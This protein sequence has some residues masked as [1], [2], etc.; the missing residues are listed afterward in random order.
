MGIPLG[1]SSAAL[2]AAGEPI[3]LLGSSG[4]ASMDAL[5]LQKRPRPNRATPGSMTTS[6]Q[7]FTCFGLSL[8]RCL[9]SSRASTEALVVP[10]ARRKLPTTTHSN[11]GTSE[12]SNKGT[13][14]RANS[15]EREDSWSVELPAEM[16][17]GQF[18]QLATE[19]EA[20]SKQ[21]DRANHSHVSLSDWS[22]RA[23][24]RTT[25]AGQARGWA[26]IGARRSRRT[27]KS[28][29]LFC[30]LLCLLC[31]FDASYQGQS[32]KGHRV[33]L[34]A[35]R[36]RK[37]EKG[38]RRKEKGEET[39]WL[40]RAAAA[41]WQQPTNESKC[42]REQASNSFPFLARSGCLPSNEAEGN[43]LHL[44]PT[45]GQRLIFVSRSR[46][47][48]SSRPGNQLERAPAKTRRSK[49]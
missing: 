7:L 29:D 43:I 13:S 49:K 20:G 36:P 6:G 10:F 3:T 45:A 33:R 28:L 2:A 37:Q 23:S 8:A 14:E 18:P 11:A 48:Q 47:A 17:A 42:H 44:T 30:S 32:E 12:R 21:P 9:S 15:S 4:S 31:F 16:F 19:Q 5:W 25:L 40:R 41:N 46:P 39:N 26:H 22:E 34:F 1:S 24:E 35:T 27:P 38:E